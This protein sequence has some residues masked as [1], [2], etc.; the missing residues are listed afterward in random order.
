MYTEIVVYVHSFS[1]TPLK[2]FKHLAQDIMDCN[3]AI[4]LATGTNSI[5]DE[6][7]SYASAVQ[8]YSGNNALEFWTNAES[9]FP[10]L[11]PLT[12]DLISAPG[13]QA[14]VER[15]LSV[16]RDLTS[17]QRSRLTNNLETRTFLKINADIITEHCMAC[18]EHW[19]CLLV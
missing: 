9:S 1:E 15:M 19:D 2:R 6:L 11:A 4:S 14:Y 5:E 17:G 18:F 10:L 13:S 16:C 3:S 12:E 8:S 7:A